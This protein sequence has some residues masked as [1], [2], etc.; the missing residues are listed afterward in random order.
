MP[1]GQGGGAAKD[2]R[3]DE[4]V[5]QTEQL[6]QRLRA[7]EAAR[8]AAGEQLRKQVADAGKMA[9]QLSS[10]TTDI[11]TL[12]VHLSLGGGG[13]QGPVPHGGPCLLLGPS[14]G[15]HLVLAL[16][17]LHALATFQP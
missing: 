12:Q 4:L 13:K 10:V 15:V 5:G 14:L 11:S 8:E 7:A 16:R 1:R 3:L 9:E 6:G 17:T 2:K